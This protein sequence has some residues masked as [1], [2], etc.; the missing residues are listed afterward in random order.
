VSIPAAA[1]ARG[2]WIVSGVAAVLLLPRIVLSWF[3][4][5]GDDPAPVV[6]TFAFAIGVLTLGRVLYV[7]LLAR[8]RSR[9]RVGLIGLAALVAGALATSAVTAAAQHAAVPAQG[10]LVPPGVALLNWLFLGAVALWLLGLVLVLGAI[11][12]GALALALRGRR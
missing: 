6:A 1:I 11:V 8:L 2:T 7:R 10:A 5:P 9:G 12:G 4:F 3:A